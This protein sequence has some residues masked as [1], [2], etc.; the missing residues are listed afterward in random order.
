MATHPYRLDALNL[1]F[2]D[3]KED[4]PSF[5]AGDVLAGSAI[6]GIVQSWGRKWAPRL[7][8][9]AYDLTGDGKTKIYGSYG[10]FYDRLKFPRHPAARLVVIFSVRIISRSPRPILTTTLLHAGKGSSATGP[11]RVVAAIR[12]PQVD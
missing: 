8:G 5:N 12:R 7:G 3:E 11:I 10:W 4:L 2:R 9:N 6:P 1:G